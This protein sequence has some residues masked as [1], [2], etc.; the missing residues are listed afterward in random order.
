MIFNL[1]KKKKKKMYETLEYWSRD[2]PDFDILENDL[3]MVS[4]L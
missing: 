1:A 4:L 2:M 3:G